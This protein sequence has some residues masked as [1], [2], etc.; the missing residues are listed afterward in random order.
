MRSSKT[1]PRVD[2]IFSVASEAAHL[3]YD[4]SSSTTLTIAVLPP[5]TAV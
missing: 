2:S 4:G 1:L 5:A 3:R